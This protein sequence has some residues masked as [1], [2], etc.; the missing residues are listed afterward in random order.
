MKLLENL[1]P[2]QQGTVFIVTGALIL[3]DIL[4]LLSPTIHYVIVLAGIGLIV[5][6]FS[7]TNILDKI[8]RKK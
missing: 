1:T 5:Y 7:L 6:G 3:L 2:V 8:Q 4:N